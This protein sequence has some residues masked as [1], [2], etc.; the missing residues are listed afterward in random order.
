MTVEEIQRGSGTIHVAKRA[1]R[2]AL[3]SLSSS[4][5][6]RLLAPRTHDPRN[7]SVYALAHGGG[8]VSG[9]HVNIDIT[10]EE[11]CALTLLTQGSTKV[12]KKKD[13]AA[14]PRQHN[15]PTN[16]TT[17]PLERISLNKRHKPAP[18]V[19]Q[20][21]TAHIHDH[22][23][24]ALLPD[25]ITPFTSA[26]Y[27]QHQRINL[28][29][30]SASL[31]LLDWFTSGRRSR[32]EEWAFDRYASKNEVFIGS[33]KDSTLL[34]RDAW[35]LED[36]GTR[37]GGDGEE[38]RERF[39]RTY[40]SRVRPYHCYANLLLIGPRTKAIADDALATF[41]Q[42]V[43]PPPRPGIKPSIRP[44]LWSVSPI[45]SPPGCDSS[46]GVV[47]RAAAM[48]TDLMRNFIDERLAGL[49]AEIGENLFVGRK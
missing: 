31:V 2:T 17:I 37:A 24:L 21:I 34:L 44:L 3:S 5:P 28:L 26:S 10:I 41:E 46:P 12:Y 42:I 1:T 6:L 48:E 23:L 38:A 47:L 27:D 16:P 11:Q 8:L 4:Y 13:R 25:P 18:D 45:P 39:G 40:E 49:E 15:E 43:I 30:P 7:I 33:G 29:N 9:D 35:L 36:E 32:G 19:F 20:S 14:P 22:A